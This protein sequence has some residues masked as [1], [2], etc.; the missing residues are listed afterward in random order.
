MA[1]SNQSSA[2]DPLD[3]TPTQETFT[4]QVT[5]IATAVA[6][7]LDHDLLAQRA[8]EQAHRRQRPLMLVLVLMLG[9]SLV[10]HALTLSRLFAVRSALRAQLSQLAD[11]MDTAQEQH[12]R[13]TVP[14]D[15]QVPINVVVPINETFVVPVNTSVQI[16]QDIEVPIDT[17]FG[18]INLP[19][20]LDVNIPIST[21][22]PISFQQDFPISTTVDLNLS[23]PIDIDLGAPQFAEPL[24][25]LRQSLLELRDEF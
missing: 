22:V 20:P 19:V 11:S 3:P 18:V 7:T 8:S 24:D 23:V 17:G 21:S 13:Y 1:E 4:E 16:K 6:A 15:Q 10:L 25:D 9:L 14:I 12:V 2:S 5:E